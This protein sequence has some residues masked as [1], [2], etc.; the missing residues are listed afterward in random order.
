[1]C[2]C[3]GSVNWISVLPKVAASD[4]IPLCD[5]L[6]R[7]YLIYRKVLLWHNTYFLPHQLSLHW[8]LFTRLLSLGGPGMMWKAAQCLGQNWSIQDIWP[9][10]APVFQYLYFPRK[11]RGR[12]H[13]VGGSGSQTQQ[14]SWR[15]LAVWNGPQMQ[16]KSSTVLREPIGAGCVGYVLYHLLCK[17]S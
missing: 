4:I 1:M 17:K 12:L 14:S 2:V 11:L 7:T 13:S 10:V 15:W 9:R 5:Q 3:V 6:P 16:S 8:F